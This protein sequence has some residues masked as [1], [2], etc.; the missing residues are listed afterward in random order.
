MQ[1]INRINSISVKIFAL[2]GLIMGFAGCRFGNYSD[3]PPSSKFKTIELYRTEPK[4]FATAVYYSDNT[5]EVR[6]TSLSALPAEVLMVYSDPVYF[7]E[8]KDDPENAYFLST[9]HDA[10]T[11][12]RVNEQGKID[13]VLHS[14]EVPL[15]KS[16]TCTTKLTMVQEGEFDRSTPGVIPSSRGQMIPYQGRLK[17]GVTM[18]RSFMG[19]CTDDFADIARCYQTPAG[20][21]PAEVDGAR[22]L[23]DL[24]VSYG[25]VLRIEDLSR[26]KALVYLV[27]FE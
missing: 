18:V 9:T 7:L 19:D 21:T 1:S 8:P 22:A 11:L 20:C 13:S 12:T 25:Q 17:I 26:V 4:A 3:P 5:N 27:D 6:E 23:L 14:E 2:G 16:T 15:W 10:S 24:Y